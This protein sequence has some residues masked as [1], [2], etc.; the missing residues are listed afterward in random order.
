M[1]NLFLEGELQKMSNIWE[2]MNLAVFIINPTGCIPQHLLSTNLLFVVFGAMQTI[3]IHY[4][5]LSSSCRIETTLSSNFLL[6]S[7]FDAGC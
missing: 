1:L 5:K 2:G 3:I 6:R 4:P 7:L